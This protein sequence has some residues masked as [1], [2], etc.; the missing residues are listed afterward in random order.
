MEITA[1]SCLGNNTVRGRLEALP[2][3]FRMMDPADLRQEIEDTFQRIEIGRMNE[4]LFA[5]M[6]GY[7]PS[8][9]SSMIETIA[10]FYRYVRLHTLN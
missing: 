7:F 6:E 4:M 8:N 10:P 5:E 3:T 9:Y 2:R 1:F